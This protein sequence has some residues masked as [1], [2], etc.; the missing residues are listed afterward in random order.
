MA[1]IDEDILHVLDGLEVQV[2]AGPILH[3]KTV[4]PLTRE[5]AQTVLDRLRARGF[6]VEKLEA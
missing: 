5:G 3:D 6:K 4:K 2:V 1:N